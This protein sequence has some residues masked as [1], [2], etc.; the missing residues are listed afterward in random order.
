MTGQS[1]AIIGPGS[2]NDDEP[3]WAGTFPM[4]RSGQQVSGRR[5]RPTN[6]NSTRVMSA[7]EI[8]R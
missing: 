8:G 7:K 6:P 2:V 5:I 1:D 4:D 3:T